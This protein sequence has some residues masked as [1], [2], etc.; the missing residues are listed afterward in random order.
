MPSQ[1][2]SSRGKA[3][4]GRHFVRC[5][6]RAGSLS[7]QR[8]R[9]RDRRTC[10]ARLWQE[11]PPRPRRPARLRPSARHPSTSAHIG[12]NSSGLGANGFESTLTYA[13]ERRSTLLFSSG[14]A[15]KAGAGGGGPPSAML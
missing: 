2:R 12:A 9:L 14:P 11:W 15:P 10:A 13:A 3:T 6:G 4:A 7:L 5:H 1:R 8:S